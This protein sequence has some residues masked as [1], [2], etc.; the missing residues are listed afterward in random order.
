MKITIMKDEWIDDFVLKLQ[1]AWTF[2]NKRDNYL[3]TN[4]KG[5]ITNLYFFLL[6]EHFD[7]TYNICLWWLWGIYTCTMMIFES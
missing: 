3:G 5:Y 7:Y 4:L 1:A 2:F 6:H